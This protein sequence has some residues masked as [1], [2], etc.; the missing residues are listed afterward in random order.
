M[1]EVGFCRTKDVG[2][3]FGYI[4]CGREVV[5]RGLGERAELGMC[6]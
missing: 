5:S 1:N 3:E 2:R 6:L 4:L